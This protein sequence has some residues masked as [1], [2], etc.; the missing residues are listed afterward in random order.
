MGYFVPCAK[1]RGI[2]KSEA[3]MGVEVT[4]RLMVAGVKRAGNNASWC[5]SVRGHGS[6]KLDASNRSKGRLRLRS[7]HTSFFGVRLCALDGRVLRVVVRPGPST[8]T[9][10]GCHFEYRCFQR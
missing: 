4:T 1:G 8:A 6:A 9:V 5:S 2:V 3:L 10:A 7:G